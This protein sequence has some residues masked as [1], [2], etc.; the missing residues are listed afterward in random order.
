MYLGKLTPWSLGDSPV[1]LRPSGL[2]YGAA[3]T[4]M[5]GGREDPPSFMEKLLNGNRDKVTREFGV[6][7]GGLAFVASQRSIQKRLG[8]WEA[9]LLLSTLTTWIKG[10]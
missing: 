6:S 2:V 9:I 3:S 10:G 8:G 5:C 1:G 4:I 7:L